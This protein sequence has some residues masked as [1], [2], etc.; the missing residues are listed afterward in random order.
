MIWAITLKIHQKRK[1]PSSVFQPV[2]H[3]WS[4]CVPQNRIQVKLL[5]LQGSRG[6]KECNFTQCTGGWN[7]L[8]QPAIQ[9]YFCPYSLLA[10]PIVQHNR[11]TAT[12]VQVQFHSSS[13]SLTHTWLGVG[14]LHLWCWREIFYPNKSIIINTAA[15]IVITHH[16]VLFTLYNPIHN[17]IF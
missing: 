16:K 4:Q 14:I 8:H 13:S 12:V 5:I 9:S 11:I 10:L 7:Q 1:K 2:L 17:A 3:S 15:A 6:Q